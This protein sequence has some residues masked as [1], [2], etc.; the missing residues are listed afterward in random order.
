MGDVRSKALGYLRDGRVA[1][2]NARTERP[3]RKAGSVGAIVRGH[4]GEHWVRGHGGDWWCTCNG[5]DPAADCAH[6]AAVQLVTGWPSA[7]AKPVGEV[8]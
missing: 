4:R 7:A 3:E 5:E 1:V 6:I 2:L 8:A